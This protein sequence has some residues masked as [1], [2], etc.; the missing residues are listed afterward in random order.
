MLQWKRFK[1]NDRT[2]FLGFPPPQTI[3]YT[4]WGRRGCQLQLCDSMCESN[5]GLYHYE[6]YLEKIQCSHIKASFLFLL[7][8]MLAHICT[9][10]LN[11]SDLSLACTRAEAIWLLLAPCISWFGAYEDVDDMSVWSGQTRLSLAWDVTLLH[12]WR[13]CTTFQPSHEEHPSMRR[14]VTWQ[15]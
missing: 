14:N 15:R 4:E 11:P 8:P 10:H 9:Y 7:L 2:H 1:E 12:P 5:Q 13:T 6:F 3:Y